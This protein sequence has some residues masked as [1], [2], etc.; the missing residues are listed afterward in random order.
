LYVGSDD[1]RK[2]LITLIRA[3]AIVKRSLPDAKL[4]KVGTEDFP[5]ERLHLL[6]R[7]EELGLKNDVIFIKQVAEEDLPLFYNLARVFVF[8]SLYEGFGLPL[9]EAMASGTPVVASWNTS[10][11]EVV[12]TAARLVNPSKPE[13]VAEQIVQVL[14]HDVLAKQLSKAG[15]ERAGQFD[16]KRQAES[17]L[18]LYT[19]VATSS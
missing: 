15:L 10:I 2:N 18:A 3:F 6:R 4:L 17:L 12:G 16:D 13:E 7:V 5:G 19:K 14:T 11:P 9:L 8:P 1:P